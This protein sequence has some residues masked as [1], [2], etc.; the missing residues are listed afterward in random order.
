MKHL[1]ILNSRDVAAHV[2]NKLLPATQRRTVRIGTHLLPQIDASIVAG[3]PARQ[4]QIAPSV[5]IPVHD[6]DPG[7][8]P[9]GHRR[10]GHALIVDEVVGS[11]AG[12][13]PKRGV[14]FPSFDVHSALGC[15][16]RYN[17]NAIPI[18]YLFTISVICQP[19]RASS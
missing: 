1:A 14:V 2:R 7:D 18:W 8:D 16:S 9:P 15:C 6:V 13:V 19:Q 5:A 12:T 11:V 17:W 10:A 3:V 4:Q